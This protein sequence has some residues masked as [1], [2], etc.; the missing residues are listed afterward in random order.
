M[1]S[2]IGYILLSLLG[3]LLFLL[4][5]PVFARLQYREEL[6]VRV[7]VFG[8]PAYRYSSAKKSAELKRK[9]DKPADKPKKE[10]NPLLDD[11]AK[12]LKTESVGAAVEELRALARIVGGAA[13]RVFKAVTVDGLQLRLVIASEDAS[14]TA[15][16]VGRVCAVLYPSLTAIQSVIRIRR[17]EVTVTP[18]Y[19]AEQGS[20]TADV[21][22]HVV[23][24][25]LVWAALCA[26]VS[27]MILQSR[28]SALVKTRE[29]LENGK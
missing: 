11:L 1:W 21:L 4:I 5:V 8:I 3:L 2:V 18:D 12:R 9:A 7:R 22:L 17:R 15:Q 25:R 6:T 14:A 28:K 10:K 29:E 13:R 24:I 19:L 27:Y 20:V 23:P 16:N 26:L